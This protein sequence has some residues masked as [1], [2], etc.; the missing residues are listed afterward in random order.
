[1]MDE[2]NARE[3]INRIQKLRKKVGLIPTDK[4]TVYLEGADSLKQ[5]IEEFT[6]F[7]QKNIKAPI[8]PLTK[9]PADAKFLIQEKF[10]DIKDMGTLTV[11]LHTPN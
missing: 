7:I 6:E 8:E 3:I 2:G 10:D 1:M 11:A 9:A 5:V 4:V